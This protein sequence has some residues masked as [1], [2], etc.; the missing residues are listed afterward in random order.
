MYN[1]KH[2]PLVL[3][4][5]SILIFVRPG[6]DERH[7]A[8][9]GTVIVNEVKGFCNA[10]CVQATVEYNRADFYGGLC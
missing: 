5:Y 2:S 1:I 3:F 8:C 7:T 10:I 9:L 4:S 6:Y